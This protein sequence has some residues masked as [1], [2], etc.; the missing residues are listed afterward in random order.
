MYENT[1]EIQKSLNN[2]DY[3]RIDVI[4]EKATA[5]VKRKDFPNYPAYRRELHRIVES[6]K[7]Y[8]ILK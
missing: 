2:Y 1:D 3:A 6:L 4:V 7:L 5:H 8:K